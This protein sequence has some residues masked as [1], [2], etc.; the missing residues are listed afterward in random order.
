MLEQG[1]MHEAARLAMY[2]VQSERYLD[3][4]GQWVLLFEPMTQALEDWAARARF[5]CLASNSFSPVNFL[6]S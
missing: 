1:R 6:A 2:V 4:Q 3:A 5:P